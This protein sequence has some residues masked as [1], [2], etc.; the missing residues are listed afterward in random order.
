[1][2]ALRNLKP[3][4]KSLPSEAISLLHNADTHI[5]R[6]LYATLARLPRDGVGARVFQTRWQ[7]KGIQGC[8]WEVTKVKLKDEG[9]HGKAWGK[10]VWRGK[11][12]SLSVF[13]ENFGVGW[14][15]ALS[16]HLLSVVSFVI[17]R[18]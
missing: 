10:L 6:T 16:A 2:A 9:K 1:M 14:N 13:G 15:A 4:L 7:S 11:F 18:T 12:A 17:W 8:Y 3:L 5:P